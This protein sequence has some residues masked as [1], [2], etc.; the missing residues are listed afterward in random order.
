MDAHALLIE[1]RWPGGRFHGVRDSGG[2]DSF[3]P[4]WPPSPFRLFQALVDGAFTG[5]WAAEDPADKVAAFTWLEGLPP[6]YRTLIAWNPIT[7]PSVQLR[8]LVL[9]DKPL[10]WGLWAMSLAVS[11]QRMAQLLARLG[12]APDERHL[13]AV[14]QSAGSG[15]RR[16]GAIS[17]V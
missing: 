5:R 15:R 17:G 9:G 1:L 3:V 8:D 13:G 10:D 4:E 11:A 16:G 12:N 14:V 2:R 6:P 7:I